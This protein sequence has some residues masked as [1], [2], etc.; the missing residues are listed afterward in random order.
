VNCCGVAISPAIAR[1]ALG[2][3]VDTGAPS[4][5]PVVGPVIDQWTWTPEREALVAIDEYIRNQRPQI[6][7]FPALRPLIESWEAWYGALDVID[8]SPLKSADTLA[9]A[10]RRRKAVNDAMGIALPDTVVPADAPQTPPE[11]PHHD[12]AAALTTVAI[13]VG[14]GLAALL[15]LKF[16]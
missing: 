15:A 5:V 9:E 13:A 6:P 11:P 12:A 7:R 2:H 3:R 16:A 1:R 10:K 8:L 4:S 14:V